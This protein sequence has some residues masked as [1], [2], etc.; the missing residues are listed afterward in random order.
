M[1]IGF[2]Q[3]IHSLPNLRYF[4]ADEQLDLGFAH[5]VVRENNF[6]EYLVEQGQVQSPIF[7]AKTVPGDGELTLGGV[8]PNII[9]R[10]YYQCDSSRQS[11]SVFVL[12]DIYLRI[13]RARDVEP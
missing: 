10:R 7:T 2:W 12:S 1:V 4:G 5:G 6:F 9:Y 3:P 13:F 11:S 8:K